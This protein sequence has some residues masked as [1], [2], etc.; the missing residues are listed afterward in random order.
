MENLAKVEENLS[1]TQADADI[2]KAEAESAKEALSRV[3]EDFHSSKEYREDLLESG[4]ASYRVGNEDARE[5]IQSLHPELDL[6]GVVPPGSEDPVAEGDADA[7]PK[8]PMAAE[9]AD[10]GPMEVAPTSG[11]TP[12]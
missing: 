4:F 3:V 12:T 7:M 2:A 5:A 6:S 11:L 9:E 1:S 8:D 10:T